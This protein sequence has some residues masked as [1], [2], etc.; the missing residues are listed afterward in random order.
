M[1]IESQ[2]VIDQ[3]IST[4]TV[5]AIAGH[6]SEM[7]YAGPQERVQRDERTFQ[8]PS[9]SRLVLGR[10]VEMSSQIQADAWGSIEL[11]I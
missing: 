1:M 8:K 2:G 3:S 10:R 4:G 11:T 6:N 5:T 7:Q 9:K